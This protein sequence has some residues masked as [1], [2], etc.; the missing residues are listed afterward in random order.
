MA[1][2]FLFRLKMF[3]YFNAIAVNGI[4]EIDM[5]VNVSNNCNNSMY[6]INHK[7]IKNGLD[8]SYLWH[9]RLAHIGKTRME[10]LQRD[11]ILQGINDESYDKYESCISGKMTKKPFNNRMERASNLLALIH[12][13]VCGPLRHVSRRG[14][15]YFLT[16][17]DDY[18]RYGYVY[19]LKHKHEVYEIFKVF[20]A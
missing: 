20:K 1:I 19:L 2:E 5:N 6:S 15:S 17:T 7:R 13:D 3:F 10:K 9:C 8:S 14:A 16:F 18:S 4:F 11:G 12:T